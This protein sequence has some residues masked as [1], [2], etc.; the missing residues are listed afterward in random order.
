[1]G[2]RGMYR[3][4]GGTA[5]TFAGLGVLLTAGVSHA[6]ATTRHSKAAPTTASCSG[7]HNLNNPT[8]SHNQVLDSYSFQIGGSGSVCTLFP[9][10]KAGDIVTAF[11]TPHAGATPDVTLV[12]YTSNSKSSQTLFECAS[13]ADTGGLCVTTAI[14]DGL[15]VHVPNCGFQIDLIY[16]PPEKDLTAGDYANQKVWIDGQAGNRSVTCAA[17]TPSPS[18]SPTGGT[19]GAHGGVQAAAT[20]P[21]TG[22]ADGPGAALGLLLMAG[23]AGLIVSGRARRRR[24]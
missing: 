4:I 9:N 5:L 2:K 20:T 17:S 7:Q 10:V 24:S 1:M 23:G 19:G 14:T 6:Q 18:P 15:T 11:L 8:T 12:S 3:G 22:A 13:T 21:A 16:G